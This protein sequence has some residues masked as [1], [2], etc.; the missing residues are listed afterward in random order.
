MVFTGSKRTIEELAD[1]GLFGFHTIVSEQEILRRCTFLGRRFAYATA[2]RLGTVD[3]ARYGI[4]APTNGAVMLATAVR[5]RPQRL[6]VAGIDLFS[7]PAGSYPGDSTTPNAYTVRH[8]RDT[9]LAFILDLLESFQGELV[10]VSEVLEREWQARQ[11][12][13]RAPARAARG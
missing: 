4:Y 10:I 9:E 7:H 5:L 3:F 6:V 8:D 2:E 12:R 13:R 1:I 11:R